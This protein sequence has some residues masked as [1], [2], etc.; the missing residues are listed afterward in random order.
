M[1][2]HASRAGGVSRRGRILPALL[3]AASLAT[4]A[5]GGMSARYGLCWP[6]RI[7]YPRPPGIVI[8]HS[9]SAASEGDRPVDAALIDRW[10]EQRGW[11]LEAGHDRYH[12]GYHYVI[13]PDGSIQTGRP[14]WMR[15]AHVR[16][17]NDYIGVCLIGNFSTTANPAGLVKPHVPT[18][19]QLDA[20]HALLFKLIRKYHLTP[21]QVLGHSDLAPTACP[22]DRFP[23][24]R[25]IARLTQETKRPAGP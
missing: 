5:A 4:L 14:E 6:R 9:A 10:H 3:L 15:G 23:L 1:S 21:E 22:G 13:L 8:H 16:G 7:W 24:A 25:V 11:G 12:I 2:A 18:P 19:A 20:L 17:A